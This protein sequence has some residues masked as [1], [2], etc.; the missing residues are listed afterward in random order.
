MPYSRRQ[1]SI[2]P[3]HS[4]KHEIVWSNL[5]QNASA[6][7][8]I[9]VAQ[10]VQTPGAPDSEVNIGST[11]NSVFF[12][13]NVNGVDN[14][15]VAQIIHWMIL[16]SPM[17]ELEV[18]DINPSLYNQKNKRF[19][20]KRGM[21]MLPEIPLGSGGTVQTKRVFVVKLPRTFK[22]FGVDD[23][24]Y[25]IYISTSTSNINMCGIAIYK[26]YR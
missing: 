8:L 9:T 6:V 23:R 4:E 15:G 21:E 18:A 16:K 7:Q 20:L 12:E 14:S 24:L 17:D 2:R 11:V 26:E 19:I 1:T 25:F 13:F 3:V 5:A 10:A 22:R